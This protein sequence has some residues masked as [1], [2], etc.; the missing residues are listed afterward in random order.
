[1]IRLEIKVFLEQED[2]LEDFCWQWG[3]QAVDRKPYPS[4]APDSIRKVGALFNDLNVEAFSDRAF[5]FFP[6]HS[7]ISIQAEE[8]IE[9]AW[10]DSWRKNFQA[11]SVGRFRIVPEWEGVEP[12]ANTLLIYPG[13]A[14]GTG[15]HETTKLMLKAIQK[16]D[17]QGK[18]VLDAGC[19]TGILAI[20]TEKCGADKIFGFDSDPD[21]LDNMQRHLEMNQSQKTRLEIGFWDDLSLESY[22]V[23]LMNITIN[24]LSELWPKVGKVLKPGGIL[25][26]SGILTEQAQQARSLLEELG[27]QIQNE[28]TL[29][30]WFIISCIRK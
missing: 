22:D 28:D 8:V 7:I 4:S 6:D 9:E 29:S 20:A 24:I 23:V 11:F 27:Y 17:L 18:S 19:G 1:M 21:C 5:S 26:S 12:D 25:I 16:L 15:Q 10:Q 30:E 14:F 3:A 13:Q 2:L